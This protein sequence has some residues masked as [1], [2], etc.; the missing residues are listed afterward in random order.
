MKPEKSWFCCPDR[1]SSFKSPP[2]IQSI[3]WRITQNT[4]RRTA[5][6]T[7]Q[8]MKPLYRCQCHLASLWMNDPF[9]HFSR[10]NT[11]YLLYHG[12]RLS[13]NLCFQ[14]SIKNAVFFHKQRCSDC[15]SCLKA[16]PVD[17][18]GM[19][20]KAENTKTTEKLTFFGGNW[21]ECWDSNSGPLEP[22]SSA[23]PNFATPGFFGAV[24]LSSDIIPQVPQECKSFLSFF[25]KFFNPI[26]CWSCTQFQRRS[27]HQHRRQAWVFQKSA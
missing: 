9:V 27:D 22:H 20:G 3:R 23:I 24:L 15:Y 25:K 26:C 12:N 18:T 16:I 5:E 6:K 2:L 11:L 13:S 1:S 14:I 7:K 17:P 19:A 4:Q 21:S 10:S 8:I